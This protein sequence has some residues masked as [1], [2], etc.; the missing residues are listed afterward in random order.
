MKI[1][2][3]TGASSGLGA[4]FA[5]QIAVKEPPEELWLIARREDRLL[6]LAEELSIPCRVLPMDLT[7]PLQ[8]RNLERTLRFEHPEISILINAAGFGKLGTLETVAS[9][10]N[11]DVIS[12]NCAALTEVTRMC[13][14]YLCPGSRVL[15]IASV[16]G[17]FSLPGLN[18]Y[19]ASKAY[20]LHFSRALRE[21]L[22]EREIKVSA[23]CPYWIRDTEF[24]AI[25]QETKQPEAVSSF[26]FAGR[27]EPIVALSL[28]ASRLNLPV[29]TPDVPSALTRLGAKLLPRT[30]MVAIWNRIR[31][32]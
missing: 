11:E 3:I 7:N 24:I 29:I 8:R 5:R 6:A 20:V 21:E 23:V 9:E 17:F 28:S 19:A 4:E 25:S 15:H 13:L 18:V 30:A 10:D 1:A 16:S 32:G 2:L 14:P 22:R 26:P 27:K 12:L 31:K